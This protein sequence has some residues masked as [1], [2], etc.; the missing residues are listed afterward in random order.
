MIRSCE[1]SPD[2]VFLLLCFAVVCGRM[3]MGLN[4]CDLGYLGVNENADSETL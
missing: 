4:S 2:D 1:M 3:V